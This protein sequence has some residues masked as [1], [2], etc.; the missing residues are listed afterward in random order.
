MAND[1]KVSATVEAGFIWNTNAH[2]LGFSYQDLPELA[3]GEATVT[4]AVVSSV[5]PA[6]QRFGPDA[7]L[8]GA[9][10]GQQ[11]FA[12]Y[13]YGEQPGDP[14]ALVPE[15]VVYSGGVNR[16]AIADTVA[17]FERREGADISITYSGCGILVSQ[18]RAGGP[19]DIYFT[20]DTTFMDMVQEKFDAPKNIS[21]TELVFLV[22]KGN[23]MGFPR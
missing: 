2:Q 12:H 11:H 7:L 22:R 6:R 9:E 14:W 4:A 1:V 13:G 18:I 19:S 3:A 8:G 23:P 16:V 17:E 5:N 15:L 20:C 21:A 10:Q